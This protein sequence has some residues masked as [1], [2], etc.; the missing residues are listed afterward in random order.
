[1][2]SLSSLENYLC[3]LNDSSLGREKKKNEGLN[4]SLPSE[5]NINFSKKKKKIKESELEKLIQNVF[6]H[7]ARNN[8]EIKVSTQILHP[9]LIKFFISYNACV[10]DEINGKIYL[11]SKL[12]DSIKI[13]ISK[14]MWFIYEFSEEFRV[15]LNSYDNKSKCPLNKF[16]NEDG[17]IEVRCE[18]PIKSPHGSKKNEARIDYSLVVKDYCGNKIYHGIEFLEREHQYEEKNL[19]YV[20][21]VRRAKIDIAGENFINMSYVWD[22]DW[23]EKKYRKWYV[24]ELEGIFGDYDKIDSEESFAINYLNNFIKSP[25]ISKMLL[26]AHDNEDMYVLELNKVFDAFNVDVGRED[27]KKSLIKNC[28]IEFRDCNFQ[29]GDDDNSI[30]SDSGSDSDSECDSNPEDENFPCGYKFIDGKIFI[31]NNGLDHFMKILYMNFFEL[32]KSNFNLDF[33]F[34]SANKVNI[35]V[36]KAA[37]HAIK[38]VYSL[39]KEI[40]L[41]GDKKNMYKDFG[42]SHR[43]NPPVI[44]DDVEIKF[45]KMSIKDTVEK[46]TNKENSNNS[47]SCKN[48]TSKYI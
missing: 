23:K 34:Y 35:R 18:H 21:T 39:L 25:E 11:V 44:P 6:N 45:K 28:D 48:R 9:N 24:G 32:K 15:R 46:Y 17:Y 2:S 41:V 33:L 31:N 16:F 29:T 43:E 36:S 13:N 26:Q 40:I 42:L 5:L 3:A 12:N 14:Q 4:F 37:I 10:K 8:P 22:S 27:V 7:F 30:L 20:Q 47:S 19:N 38:S 1:M